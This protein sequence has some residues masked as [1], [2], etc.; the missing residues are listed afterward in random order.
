MNE[1]SSCDANIIGIRVEDWR[2]ERSS[3]VS[4]RKA[5]RRLRKLLAVSFDQRSWK[6]GTSSTCQVR[7]GKFGKVSGLPVDFYITGNSHN[8]KEYVQQ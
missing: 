4:G 7:A 1:E 5:A 8:A 2:I 6:L 3:S